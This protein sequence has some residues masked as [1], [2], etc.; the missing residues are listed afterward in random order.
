MKR[1]TFIL[2]LTLFIQTLYSQN[3]IDFGKFPSGQSDSTPILTDNLLHKIKWET[4]KKYCDTARWHHASIS[5]DSF[6]TIY[7][8]AEQ[9][10]VSYFQIT[11]YKGLV[12]QYD[13]E[14]TNTTQPSRSS[15]FDKNVWMKYVSDEL[16]GLPEI[17]K[18]TTEEPQGILKSYYRLL[19]VN[20]RDEYGWICEYSATGRATPKR[21]AVLELVKAQRIDLLKRLLEYSNVQTQLYAIDA[22]IYLDLETR[23]KIENAENEI[24]QRNERLDSLIALENSNKYEIEGLKQSIKNTK[25]FIKYLKDNLLTKKT[26]KAIHDLRDANKAVR[27]CRDGTG[28]YKVYESNTSDILSDKAIKELSNNYEN[29]KRFG[30]L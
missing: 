11:S 19:G 23:K 30:Y 18:L 13:S 16:P 27:T 20:T 22:L 29:L 12:L 14:I 5:K 4:I 21:L 3:L 7:E 8:Y 15:Y 10:Y 26:W 28:S 1:T 9:G 25:G 6:M 2:V 24:E 17:F